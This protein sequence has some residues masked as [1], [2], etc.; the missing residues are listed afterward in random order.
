MNAF[1][2]ANLHQHRRTNHEATDVALKCKK[3]A[4]SASNRNDFK[5]HMKTHSRKKNHKSIHDSPKL[6]M[7]L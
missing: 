3:C 5:E 7:L 1:I 6:A 4:F 2:A